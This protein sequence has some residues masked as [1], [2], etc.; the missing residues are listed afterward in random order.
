MAAHVG[1]FYA[2]IL[3]NIRS[4]VYLGV[5]GYY[6]KTK[7]RKDMTTVKPFFSGIADQIKNELNKAQYSIRVAMYSL[8][9]N[10][11]FNPDFAV[12]I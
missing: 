2:K 1:R 10:C 7:Q 5:A 6:R 3:G 9:D 12:G 4:C 11:L 8:N